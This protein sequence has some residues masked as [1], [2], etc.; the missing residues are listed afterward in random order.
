MLVG[1]MSPEDDPIA[2]AN[3][4]VSV[5][6][7]MR[8]EHL[9]G[10]DVIVP[11]VGDATAPTLNLGSLR[12]SSLKAQFDMGYCTSETLGLC[13]WDVTTTHA[14]HLLAWQ[15]ALGVDRFFAH[16]FFMATDGISNYEAPP[17]Y[18][19]KT[20]VF[21][22]ICAMSEW[23]QACEALQDESDDVAD[24]AV[25]SSMLSFWTYAD[26]MDVEHLRK[27]RRSLWWTILGCLQAQ[28]G[29]H[30]VDEADLVSATAT[31]AGITVGSRTYST[32]LMPALDI[33]DQ[34]TLDIC[35]SADVRVVWFGN[36]PT[37]ALTPGRD[38]VAVSDL[39][40]TRLAD[41][42][43]S[44][45]WCREQLSPQVRVLG[46]DND[47]CYV[48]RFRAASGGAEHLFAVNISAEHPLDVVLAADAEGRCWHPVAGLVDGDCVPVADGTRWSVGARGCGMF[49]LRSS[50]PAC[51]VPEL[52]RRELCTT[53]SFE[54]L[55][56]N[57]LRLDS[58]RVSNGLAEPVSLDFPQ[59]YWQVFNDYAAMRCIEKY[60]GPVPVESSVPASELVYAFEFACA[61]V[62]T[63]IPELVLEPRVARGRFQVVLNDAPV[64]EP[65]V[66]PLA[67]T[68]ALR[69]PLG[70]L[71]QGVNRLEL[72]FEPSSAMDGL[73]SLIFVV[74]EFSVTV[75]AGTRTLAA[76]R[77]S[78]GCELTEG[79]PAAG[80][81]Y[82]MGAGR[83]TWEED[84]ATAELD[85]DWAL[86]LDQVVDS[87]DL[88]VNG[89]SQ[90][91]RAWAPWRWA[92]SGLCAGP[93]T[94]ELTV[95]STAGN[96]RKLRWPNQAQGWLG[97]GWLVRRG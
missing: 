79:W 37:Q 80:A 49:E 58:C 12:I 14:R 38:L 42:H 71:R 11:G 72:R 53:R 66:F 85:G 93:N 78:T 29:L 69:L 77:A 51:A 87:A 45:A 40:G 65:C 5:M 8:A 48:R 19:P 44:S 59:P 23:L 25:L 67:S 31:E 27:L 7:V 84:F 86:V 26:G 90:G 9:P 75:E 62:P 94:F 35:A 82:Y 18:G 3:T 47:A 17:D 33:V 55:G 70:A 1:H 28:V 56:P 83:Y 60:L 76:T 2:E 39:P 36:G 64:G 74:G 73:L 21:H 89:V 22:G 96:M 88:T 41:L 34:R 43:P 16:G 63:A 15:R 6:P 95:H 30:I 20:S 24:V 10:T 52:A 4:V 91:V 13:E 32:L 57:T 61:D 92:L 81:P 50:Q 68:A 46:N 97:Q 54:L